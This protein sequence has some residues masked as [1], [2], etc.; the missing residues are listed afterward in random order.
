MSYNNCTIRDCW[1]V[2][3]RSINDDFS[4]D[5]IGAGPSLPFVVTWP[6][7]GQ[8]STLR[9]MG[10]PHFTPPH[11]SSINVKVGFSHSTP[12]KPDFQKI[13]FSSKPNRPLSED[14]GPPTHPSDSPFV[15]TEG[16]LLYICHACTCC[17]ILGWVYSN[18]ISLFSPSSFPK[19][20]AGG[21]NG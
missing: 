20:L 19:V 18:P 10:V 7:T 12:T 3:T 21:A 8:Q 15:Q 4:Q 16:R 14:N 6:G 17:A 11:V 1:C 5:E 2:F 13:L 9:L